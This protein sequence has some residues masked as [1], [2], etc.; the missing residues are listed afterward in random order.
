[1][2]AEKCDRIIVLNEGR[3]VGDGDFDYISQLPYFE[4]LFH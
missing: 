2:F 1:M 3:I 4:G